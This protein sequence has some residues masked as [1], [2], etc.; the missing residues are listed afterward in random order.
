[1]YKAVVLRFVVVDARA[2]QVRDAEQQHAQRAAVEAATN[3]RGQARTSQADR[4]PCR[5][6]V[7]LRSAIQRPAQELRPK[8]RYVGLTRAILM[9]VPAADTREAWKVSTDQAYQAST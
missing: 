9:F 8:C 2:E 7:L 6:L 5:A 4:M 3:A 1:M